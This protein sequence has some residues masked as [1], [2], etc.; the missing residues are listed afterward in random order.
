MLLLFAVI[1]CFRCGAPGEQDAN[2]Q[3]LLDGLSDHKI[4][5]VTEEQI[6]AAAYQEGN[7][8]VE[9]FQDF[10]LSYWQT[11][12]GQNTLDSLNEVLGH[13]GFKL[14]SDLTPAS[15]VNGDEVALMEAYQ[16]SSSQGQNL[17]ENVQGSSGDYLLF[18]SPVVNEKG[19]LGMWSLLLS[20]KTLVRQL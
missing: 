15:N 1:C 12:S 7:A 8:I 3:K 13:G 9:N 18:T 19:F 17:A 4:K 2:R 11:Q 14:I 16:Y 10:E 6:H 5:R 20:K